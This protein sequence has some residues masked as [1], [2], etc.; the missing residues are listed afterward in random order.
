M[1][2]CKQYYTDLVIKYLRA[3]FYPGYFAGL[4]TKVD[5]HCLNTDNWLQQQA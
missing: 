3:S 5:G 2:V 1:G 4:N